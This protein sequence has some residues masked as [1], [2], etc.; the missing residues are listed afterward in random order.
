MMVDVDEVQDRATVFQNSATST[1]SSLVGS[2]SILD[3]HSEQERAELFKGR[4]I[5]I[6]NTQSERPAEVAARFAALGIGA[7]INIPR[8]HHGRCK[9]VLSLTRAEPTEWRDDQVELLREVAT[10]IHI[11]LERARAEER[12]HDRS[13]QLDLLA[14]ISQ[15][16]VLER[17][18]ERELLT[19]IFQ[20]IAQH[21]GVEMYFHYC[22]AAEP[23]LLRLETFGGITEEE[24]S[25]FETMPF[26]E[27]LCGRVAETCERLI[28]ED[29]Q[30]STQPGSEV[31]AAAGAKS[32]AGFPLIANG[33]L[34]GTLAFISRERVHFREGEMQMVQTICDQIATTLERTRLTRELRK[35]EARL[36]LGLNVAELA[37]AEIDYQS[38][39][40]QMLA[41]AAR[42]FGLGDTD[43]VIR[44]SVLHDRFHPDNR[45]KLMREIARSL[46][47][48]GPGWF[49][50]THR[51]LLP[52]GEVRHV[53]VRKLIRFGGG[54]G[55]ARFA[56]SA[57]LAAMDVTSE[58]QSNERLRAAHDTFR[59]LVERS[60]F[61][62]YTIDADFRVVQVSE[63]AQKTF[64]NVR[65]LL[66]RD[67]VEV[68]R[69]LWP[70][71]FAS[72]VIARFRHTL[73]TGESYVAETT[74]RRA[75]IE[76]TEAY[77]WKIERITMPDGR[78]GVVC[79]FYDLSERKRHEE[80]VQLL[81]REVIHRSMNMLSLVQAIARQTAVTRPDDFI[82]RFEQRI[83][84]LAAN[85]NLLIRSDWRSVPLVELVRSQLAHFG[86][87]G[88]SRVSI[89]GPPV[90]LNASAT[91][92]LG[93]ALH[94]LAS[95]AAKYGAFSNE[96]GLVAITWNV[97]SHEP[98][99]ARFS[100]S[101]L[102]SGG[103]LVEGPTRRG[104][105]STVIDGM[106]KIKLK[107]N[108]TIDFAPSGL[109]WR[110]DC[111]A[112]DVLDGVNSRS[113]ASAAAD[114]VGPIYSVGRRRVLVVEDEALIAM[115]IAAILLEA[116]LEVI[117]PVA[118]VAKALI[119]IAVIGCDVAVLDYNLGTETAEPIA[120]DLMAK[121]IPFVVTSGYSPEQLPSLLRG[122]PLLGKPLKPQ[123]L[124]AEVGRL[125][126]AGIAR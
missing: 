75:D 81:M 89:N 116:G 17:E 39:L 121:D 52:G 47:P 20:N 100:M 117:G 32:Y 63:G 74:E 83:H 88:D 5:V 111:P 98:N 119:M 96:T 82:Q 107:C 58:V 8:M 91:Q 64:E 29:L 80:H 33:E 13:Q 11:R 9:F 102:E 55:A 60:P 43:T 4:P 93:M 46:D 66:G 99:Q 48:A 14:R 36:A 30:H 110:I 104:F 90:D 125:A 118:A 27:L 38:E 65:P 78:P 103:P 95:N 12:L 86:E 69:I 115:E 57:L 108:P 79:H 16:L 51:I 109:M 15:K 97:Y 53:R 26:G 18:N 37:I 24:R 85:Q 35:S 25:R 28:V 94:E 31:L 59:Q 7:L 68:L 105:G 120:R 6:Y 123:L 42:L 34:M 114:T 40:V 21:L 113:L 50:M 112:E 70:E 1:D 54:D 72:E 77:D 87:T 106:V 122:A 62:L 56:Q 101:W 126:A 84:A 49:A 92:S 44:R 2:H 45:D 71:P 61:G 23:R 3:F 76:G 41:V 73:E 10:W 22:P 124:V 19:S 67:L